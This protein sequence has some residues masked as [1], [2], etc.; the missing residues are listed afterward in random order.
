ML[1][2]LGRPE[3]AYDWGSENRW[4]NVCMNSKLGQHRVLLGARWW[5]VIPFVEVVDLGRFGSNGSTQNS[6]WFGGTPKSMESGFGKM[7]FIN[8]GEWFNLEQLL[9]HCLPR[10]LWKRIFGTP[11]FEPQLRQCRS[12]NFQPSKWAGLVFSWIR[13]CIYLFHSVPFCSCSYCL[14]RIGVPETCEK[15][16]DRTR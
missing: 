10:L 15:Y 4:V 3:V 14:L 13:Y 5:G 2:P 8:L 11:R 1:I 9:F 12:K 16:I 7:G 6:L